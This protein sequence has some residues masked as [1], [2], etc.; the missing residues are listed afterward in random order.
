MGNSDDGALPASASGK[1]LK[2]GG[3]IG[4]LRASRSPCRLT[5]HSTQ[6][7]TAFTDLAAD[8]F[9]CALVVSGTHTGPTR[10]MRCARE[11]IAIGPHLCDETPGSHAIHPGNRHPTIQCLR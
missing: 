2:L 8:A 1:L 7:R 11:L 10:Q 3:E 4:V 9:A 6:P 5:C